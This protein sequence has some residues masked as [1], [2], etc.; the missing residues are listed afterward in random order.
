MFDLLLKNGTV[1]DPA[2]GVSR[3]ADVGFSGGR[4]AAVEPGLDGPS[5]RVVDCS[6]RIVVPGLVD[7]HTHTF[8]EASH[9]GLIPDPFCLDRGVT[10][11]IDAGSAGADTFERTALPVIAASKTRIRAL[12]HISRI[13]MTS[14]PL[15]KEGQ[16]NGELAD[17]ANADVDAAVAMGKR[18]RDVI[19]GVK[20]RLTAP[21]M[22]PETGIEPL[23]RASAA[24]ERLELPLMV[25]PQSA[26]C[27]SIDDILALLRPG[28]IVTHSFHRAPCGVLD[29]GGRVRGAVWRAA[30]R[31]VLFDVGH[32]QASLDFDVFEKALADGF[33][34]LTISSDG[35]AHSVPAPAGDL[36]A[37]LSKCMVFGFGIAELI[38]KATVA[39]A[40]AVRLGDGI[41]SLAVGGI[42]DATVLEVERGTFVVND[43]FGETRTG[44]ERLVARLAV[45]AGE[46]VA[47]KPLAGLPGGTA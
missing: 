23:R 29:D 43:S 32:G 30:E 22:R 9:Y 37:T 3:P 47:I 10:T 19:V 41:G 7:L 6:G 46:A 14:P 25:H 31:G 13:G 35:H 11:A 38:E 21:F 8:P 34:P 26:R 44:S 42:G 36:V 4:V 1:I 5:A 40:R 16:P 2:Q 18:H 39:P 17:L 12:L 20:V 24:A 15:M 27:D 28:D 33:R 45:R